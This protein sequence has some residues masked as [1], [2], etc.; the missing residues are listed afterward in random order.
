MNQKQ[1]KSLIRIFEEI[2][3]PLLIKN[4]REFKFRVKRGLA[5]LKY[6]LSRI[7]VKFN[8]NNGNN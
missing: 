6:E 2:D 4:E 7:K 3:S 1:I 5:L 8:K